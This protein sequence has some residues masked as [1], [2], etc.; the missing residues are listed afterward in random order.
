[1]ETNGYIDQLRVKCQKIG[2]KFQETYALAVINLAF[3]VLA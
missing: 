3:I 1:M 2:K